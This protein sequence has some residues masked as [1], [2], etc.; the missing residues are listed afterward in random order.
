M[1]KVDF[2]Y[3]VKKHVIKFHTRQSFG[4]LAIFPFV[5]LIFI[6]FYAI[7]YSFMKKNTK[8]IKDDENGEELITINE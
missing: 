4:V 6:F 3:M 8:K 7:Y 5:S 1:E 2:S